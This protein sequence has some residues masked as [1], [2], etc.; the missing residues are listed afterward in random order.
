MNII[1]FRRPKPKQFNYIPR[2]YDPLKDE[3]EERKRELG[4]IQDGDLKAKM[5]A[6]IRRRWRVERSPSSRQFF[7]MRMVVY[8]VIIAI[9]LYFIFFSNFINH[10][11]SFFVK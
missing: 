3:L 2:Y 6:D 4:L 10:F 11:V 9:T 5:R 8:T 1:F 7:I